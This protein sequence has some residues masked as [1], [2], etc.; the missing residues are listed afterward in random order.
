MRCSGF[1]DQPL[2]HPGCQPDFLEF[3]SRNSRQWKYGVNYTLTNGV[4]KQGKAR[5]ADP[6]HPR[7]Q[8]PLFW[9]NNP[10][11]RGSLPIYEF[12]TSPP[13]TAGPTETKR[14]KPVFRGGIEGKRAGEGVSAAS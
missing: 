13:H 4:G 8:N 1:S 3:S 9:K 6:K 5:R 14:K 2:H 7:G 12:Q 11:I 10:E